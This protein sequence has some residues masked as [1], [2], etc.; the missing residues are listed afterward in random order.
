ME[1]SR[2]L[3]DFARR[4]R[5]AGLPRDYVRSAAEELRDHLEDAR[6]MDGSADIDRLG[7]CR[8]LAAA[9]V[10]GYRNSSM[11][12]R[13]PFASLFVGGAAISAACQLLGMAVW[14]GLCSVTAPRAGAGILERGGATVQ[15]P[16][17]MGVGGWSTVQIVNVLSVA[18]AVPVMLSV[19]RAAGRGRAGLCL[20][21]FWPSLFAPCTPITLLVPVG[22]PAP[23]A[24]AFT[25]GLAWGEILLPPLM[26]VLVPVRIGVLLARSR[27]SSKT[28]TNISKLLNNHGCGSPDP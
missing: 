9:Y 22:A 5:R 27:S 11:I 20:A 18:L 1:G 10:E 6:E 24:F 12:G 8:E 19:A 17:V 7:G 26:A 16:S 28:T 13:Y 25:Y 4:L 2:F 15:S 23:N 21:L 3:D 14:F